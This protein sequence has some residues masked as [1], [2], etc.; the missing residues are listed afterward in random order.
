MANNTRGRRKKAGHEIQQYR[1]ER[2]PDLVPNPGGEP[3]R[4]THL[5]DVGFALWDDVV[6]KLI[7]LNIA[8]ALDQYQLEAMCEWWQ[9]Y[10]AGYD[11]REKVKAFQ[12]FSALAAKF[13]MT[14]SDRR[15]LKPKPPKE[16]QSPFAAYLEEKRKLQNRVV[17]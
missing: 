15:K 12:E 6:P 16:I 1:A 14:P 5:N 11:V 2:R 4:P 13:G 7:E 3:V 8:T 10:K 17:G 9:F